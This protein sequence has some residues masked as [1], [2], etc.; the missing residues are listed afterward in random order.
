MLR[1]VVR[2]LGS[3]RGYRKMVWTILRCAR[4]GTTPSL[5]R[6]AGRSS[7]QASPDGVGLR[8]A[9]S[10]QDYDLPV[11]QRQSSQLG[12]DEPSVSGGRLLSRSASGCGSGQNF[13]KPASL[14]YLH[15]KIWCNESALKL[16]VFLVRNIGRSVSVSD[17]MRLA[18][19]SFRVGR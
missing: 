5:Y 1:Q 10:R 19:E 16:R 4:S 2:W 17:R 15:F 12:H 9:P 14:E 11:D 3:F 18:R 13:S 6:G 7:A 8:T